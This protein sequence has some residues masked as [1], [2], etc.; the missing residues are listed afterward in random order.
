MLKSLENINITENI[1][2]VPSRMKH[3]MFI[4]AIYF[5]PATIVQTDVIK[6][7]TQCCKNNYIFAV[8]SRL[9]TSFFLFCHG[10]LKAGLPN[11]LLSHGH[12]PLWPQ[13]CLNT[14]SMTSFENMPPRHSNS[15]LFYSPYRFSHFEELNWMLLVNSHTS[16]VA[17][18]MQWICHA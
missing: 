1:I 13:L 8:W 16:V 2:A 3:K 12:S 18:N 6:L 9:H 7:V 17:L 4:T 14:Q 5:S 10:K 11:M 15:L